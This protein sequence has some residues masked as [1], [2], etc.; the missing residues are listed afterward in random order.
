ME[1]NFDC[2]FEQLMKQLPKEAA[3]QALI[4]ALLAIQEQT[5]PSADFLPLP[6]V[7]KLY[8]KKLSAVLEA[9]CKEIFSKKT[10]DLFNEEFKK[11][12]RNETD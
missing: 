9:N 12:K 11:E 7:I 4:T 6:L 5:K 8:S 1:I 2:K 10:M 3:C